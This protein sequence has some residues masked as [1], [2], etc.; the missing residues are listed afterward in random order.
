MLEV[1]RQLGPL[2]LLKRCASNVFGPP[3]VIVSENR[4]VAL[5][6]AMV[7]AGLLDVN[8]AISGRVG[9]PQCPLYPESGHVRCS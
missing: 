2:T 1:L 3:W 6:A 5:V 8:M 9:K 7:E 4:D